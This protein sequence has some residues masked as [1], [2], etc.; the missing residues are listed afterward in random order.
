MNK[1]AS[2][3][4]R[5]IVL[6]VMVVMMLS[7]ISC[8]KL[9]F[10]LESIFKPNNDH[11]D[12]EAP[13][14]KHENVIDSKCLD[15]KELIIS[16]V[17]DL[18]ALAGTKLSD[19]AVSTQRYYIRATV[20]D[21]TNGVSGAMIL[22][23]ET[24]SIIVDALYE[25]N[26]TTYQNMEK[27]PDK[28][29]K[30]LFHCILENRGGT[31][32]IKSAYLVE[33][34]AIEEIIE[35]PEYVSMTVK[36]ARGAAT[37]A[38][39]RVKGVVAQITY[40]F[41]MV[42]SGVILVDNTGSIYVYDKALADSVAVGNTVDITATKTYWILESEQS[43]ADKFGYKG[44][45]QLEKV[46]LLTND[47]GN[48]PF[49]KSWITETTVKEIIDTPASEDITNNIFKVSALIK[50]D[51]GNGFTNYYI[52]DIDGITGSY[53]YS[54][55]NGDDFA[56]L[57]KFDGKICTVYM[58]A[59]NAKSTSSACF[60]RLLPI[61]VSDDGYTFDLNDAAEYAVKY[62]GIDQFNA[63]Y[64]GDPAIELIT[65]VSSALLG[66]E[67]A[68]LSYSSSDEAVVYFTEGDGVVTLHCKDT[69]SATVTVT[70][71]YGESTYSEKVEITVNENEEI[72]TIS[73][74]DAIAKEI[75]DEVIIC[76]IVGPSL[77]NKVGFY[78]F[79]ESG[80]IAVTVDA[81]VLKEIAIGN[82]VVLKGTRDMFVK[83]QK[84]FG[85]ICVSNATVESNYYGN[86]DYLTIDTI[87]TTIAEFYN[88][89]E[90]DM[91]F[92]TK[93]YV[94]KATVVVE[95]STFYTNIYLSDGTTKIRLYCSGADQYGWL[96]DFEGEEV[97]VEIAPCNWNS[98]SYYTGC[99]LAV[100]KEDGT[101]ILNTLNFN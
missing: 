23:D 77:V 80:M 78:L 8:D 1:S 69:G 39:V 100:V 46:T 53:S 60:W 37:G 52:N 82:E 20:K 18:M 71:S 92:E 81:S 16:T 41:G 89:D 27:K 19:G 64:T 35:T 95:R 86:H 3:F 49:D 70:G 29:D 4:I 51:P 44:A 56:W 61:E 62:H 38:N 50:K 67:G 22:E 32:R 88:F 30:V 65:S 58:V 21:L 28:C 84:T 45:C 90:M 57:E 24:G 72:K 31:I 34:E 75:G 14:C 11:G 25:K 42:P 91:S 5:L 63:E 85:Q 43:N 15:C 79:D 47:K 48:T 12:D 26:G 96:M 9:P 66:F 55:C 87:N 74:A 6:T 59:I 99:A 7:L 68:S 73:I 36:E 83:N 94:V 33:F 13:A 54:Q 76:G 101:K 93:V 40:A 10:D 98:Q 2:T 97:T 17:E